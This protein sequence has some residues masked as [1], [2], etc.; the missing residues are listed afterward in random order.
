[1]GHHINKAGQFRSA[2]SVE[3]GHPDLPVDKIV[4]SFKH[5]EAWPALAA[6]AESYESIDP[7]LA[8]DIRTRLAS[9]KQEIEV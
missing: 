3:G 2:T 9:V 6:L 7:E 4:V 5:R 8:A 1:M